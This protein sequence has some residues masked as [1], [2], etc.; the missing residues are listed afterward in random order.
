MYFYWPALWCALKAT[1]SR[2]HFHL[3]HASFVVVLLTLFF[4]LRLLVQVIRGLDWLVYPKFQQVQIQA[5]IYIIGNP[6]S[7]TTYL[8]RLMALD[9][10]FTSMKLY[11]T[12]FPAVIFNKLFAGLERLDKRLGRQ[13]TRWVDWLDRQGFKGWEGIHKTKL[14]Q[15]EE[16]EQLFVFAALSPVI[17]L[18]F[19]FPEALKVASFVDHQSRSMQRRLMAY[20]RDCLQRHLYS[21]GSDKTLLVKNTTMAGRLQATREQFPDMRMIHLVRSTYD[22]IPS[23]L[24][25]NR[26]AW[27][28]FVPQTRQDNRYNR[29]VAQVY[30]EYFRRYGEFRAS[31]PPNQ[32][33][34]VRYEDLVADPQGTIERIYAKL[35]I[36]MTPAYADR[37]AKTVAQ[38]KRYKSVH[39]YSL[40]EFGLSKQDIDQALLAQSEVRQV[41]P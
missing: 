19:P 1:F 14:G 5:P 20:Y 6:R 13:L 18:L 11:Q 22:A 10:Q 36:T 9:E 35:G 23:F 29:S 28:R 3:V 40:E 7:G 39:R 24:S 15:P 34:E 41:I 4:L 2:R 33:I 21:A 25:M 37:L 38:T 30:C 27:N 12:I 32:A 8:H 26:A 16:D 31:L 17:F